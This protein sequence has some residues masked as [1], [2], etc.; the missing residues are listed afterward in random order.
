[1]RP[2]P[3]RVALRLGLGE[4]TIRRLQARG[5][6]RRLALS[7]PE[8]RERLYRAHLAYLREA[9]RR[10]RKRPRPNPSSSRLAPTRRDPSC[11]EPGIIAP[12]P[13]AFGSRT[14]R[15]LRGGTGD[16][17]IGRPPQGIDRLEP[18]A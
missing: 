4:A 8:I 15:A 17:A 18:V 9:S 10:Q 7:E 2:E 1:M 14:A 6:L 12:R 16:A 11:G 5:Y 3:H 13:P